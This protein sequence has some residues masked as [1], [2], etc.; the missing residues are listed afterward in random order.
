LR[1]WEAIKGAK[2][3]LF[4]F[5]FK[6]SFFLGI[7]HFFFVAKATL[8][9]RLAKPKALQGL[10]KKEKGQA[11]N[12]LN[13]GA[14]ILIGADDAKKAQGRKAASGNRKKAG[15]RA[16]A[17]ACKSRYASGQKDTCCQHRQEENRGP[18]RKNHSCWSANTGFQRPCAPG[19][20]CRGDS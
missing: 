7:L 17:Q 12:F 11:G 20:V 13:C 10:R 18:A 14:L 5:F 6:I 1:C 8:L 9:R 15:C 3:P 16:G 2:T 4:L 19:N